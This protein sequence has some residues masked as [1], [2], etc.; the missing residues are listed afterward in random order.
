MVDLFQEEE[1]MTAT[2]PTLCARCAQQGK[3]C[4]QGREIYITPEDRQ[5]IRL[6][7]GK[8]EFVE[9]S[10]TTDPAY[11]DQDDDPI[12]QRHVLDRDGR[13]RILKRKPNGDC[14]FLG[15][16]GCFLPMD[17]RPLLCRLH[18][19]T[20]TA[21]RIDAEPDEGCPRHLLS[22]EESVFDAIHMTMELARQWH[23][24][25]YEEIITDDHDDRIDLRPSL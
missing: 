3:T 20:Y 1:T 11:L 10:P 13:R 19:L 5:R 25:L 6:L 4:C 7:S 2:Q 9:W 16:R 14:L 8:L 24:Q 17:V 21:D 15:T 12:W 22:A 18:P 23:R